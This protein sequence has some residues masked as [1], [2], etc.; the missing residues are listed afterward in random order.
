MDPQQQPRPEGPLETPEPSALPS[1]RD[2]PTTSAKDGS[3]GW[4]P[5]QYER[6]KKERA[7]PFHDLLALVK[8]RPGMRAVDLGCGTG[9]LTAVLHDS[10]RAVETLGIDVSDEMLSKSGKFAREALAFRKTDIASFEPDGQYDLLFSNA[11]LQWLPD[12][13][14]LFRRLASMLGPGGQIAVQMPANDDHPSH[15]VARDLARRSPY[16]EALSGYTGER[17]LLSPE[18]YAQLIE[19]L[20]FEEQH[21]R[22]QVYTHRLSSREEV[23]EWVKGALLTDFQKRMP[24]ELFDRFVG[25]YRDS[26]M[27]LL[28]DSK[29]YLY[30]FK[31]LLIWGGSKVLPR[32]RADDAGS[33]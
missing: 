17:G 18:G 22:L 4:D 25:E 27:P 29:P 15:A 2:N 19:E 1:L 3:S 9:E 16:L 12:H 5:V 13:E 24:P 30:T 31:R 10:T 7:Q 11:A 32:D 8:V 14:A 21:V 20:G 23:V 33:P 26:L 6:F 28:E